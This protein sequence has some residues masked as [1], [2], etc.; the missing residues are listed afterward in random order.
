MQRNQ[1]LAPQRVDFTYLPGIIYTANR[2]RYVLREYKSHAQQSPRPY[3]DL[4]NPAH[5]GG[6]LNVMMF[7]VDGGNAPLA[8]VDAG[9]PLPWC[10]VG[11][12]KNDVLTRPHVFF[13]LAIPVKK[14]SKK[15]MKLFAAVYAEIADRLTS[16]G[17][18]IDVGQK[19]IQKNPDSTEWDV[20][21]G[22][23]RT[24]TLYQLAQYLGIDVENYDREEVNIFAKST[25]TINQIY[26]DLGRNCELFEHVRIAAY[27]YKNEAVNYE[28]LRRH[29]AEIAEQYN[30]GFKEPLGAADVRSVV[31]SVALWTWK[32][33]NPAEVKDRGAAR[34]LYQSHHSKKKKQAAGAVYTNS[35]R[36]EA[37][38][39]RIKAARKADPSLTKK[40]AA[41][42]LK[43]D[44]HTVRK[45]WDVQDASELYS[46]RQAEMMKSGVYVLTPADRSKTTAQGGGE[47]GA[48]RVPALLNNTQDLEEAIVNRSGHEPCS[49]DVEP[50]RLTGSTAEDLLASYTKLAQTCGDMLP[51]DTQLPDLYQQLYHAD[52]LRLCAT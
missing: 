3:I 5:D 39:Q 2:D 20:V 24:W 48:I 7:D 36:S 33:Y 9:L 12:W 4:N 51:W 11:T 37:T 44:I 19:V 35:K 52:L 32:K 50:V 40:G 46:V 30:R 14:T 41:K 26:A 25:A 42:A 34:H 17:C 22:E 27:G 28:D 43:I 6:L 16:E 1:N 15:A 18:K 47:S 45:Y 38:L 21:P 13:K 8:F 10:Y 23:D 49:D 29:V 31:K